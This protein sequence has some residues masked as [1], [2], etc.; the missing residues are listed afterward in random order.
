[1]KYLILILLV[2]VLVGCASNEIIEV[3]GVFHLTGP[4]S[5][6]GVGE[7]NAALLAVEKINENG[8]INGK[9]LKFIVE[10]GQTDFFE[11]NT[12][13]KKLI[14]INHV[15]VIIGPTWFGQVAMPIA[16]ET[17]TVVLSPSTGV[18]VPREK[19]FFNLW[20]TEKQEIEA[21]IDYM[22]EERVVVV[23]SQNDWTIS[24]K[25]EFIDE[26]EKKGIEIVDMYAHLPDEEDFRTVLTN[27]DNLGV[28]AVYGAFAFYSSQGSFSKQFNELGLNISFYSTSGTENFELLNAYPEIENT[29]YPYPVKSIKESEFLQ[30]YELRF[31]IKAAPSVAYAYDAVY[32]VVDA[33]KSGASNSEEIV[34]YLENV[35]Y[36]GV[37]DVQFVNGRITHKEYAMKLVENGEFVW[38]R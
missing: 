3:G 29:L 17:N 22:N 37:N 15:E 26:A 27:I 35:T 38:V 24:M 2:L 12:V 5:F 25:D 9:K 11:T 36:S 20:P 28:D 31:D 8:G 7:Y 1:M 30:R 23:Y 34:D 13:L 19:Y 16:E 14:D 6:W 33:L 10:D 18:T 4:G 32:L 21:L